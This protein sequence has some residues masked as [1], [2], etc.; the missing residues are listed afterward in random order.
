MYFCLCLLY[1]QRQQQHIFVL[2]ALHT[3]KISKCRDKILNN[4][5]KNEKR[6]KL[7][8]IWP[9]VDIYECY[10]NWQENRSRITKS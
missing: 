10:E 9:L 1:R 2:K 3:L 6:F 7:F 8:L 4:I 5:L